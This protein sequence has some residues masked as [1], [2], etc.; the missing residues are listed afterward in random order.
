M[1]RQAMHGAGDIGEFKLW[2][3]SGAE[4]AGPVG[5]RSAQRC[6]MFVAVHHQGSSQE[7]S[8]RHQVHVH[9]ARY[10]HAHITPTQTLRLSL[11]AEHGGVEPEIVTNLGFQ[12]ALFINQRPQGH[13]RIVLTLI[14]SRPVAK[15]VNR[16]AIKSKPSTGSQKCL[17]T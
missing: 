1:I 7:S 17:P 12:G 3:H 10:R 4:G 8:N 13:A 15:P 5:G 6:H 14:T 2:C 9:V 16:L 11:P